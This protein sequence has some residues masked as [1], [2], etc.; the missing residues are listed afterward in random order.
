MILWRRTSKSFWCSFS[1][2]PS[3]CL[4]L[5]CRGMTGKC[6][7]GRWKEIGAKEDG[8]GFWPWVQGAGLV[9][10]RGTL[11]GAMSST[12]G[13]EHG[14]RSYRGRILA[15][16]EVRAIVKTFFAQFLPENRQFVQPQEATDETRNKHGS[17]CEAAFP[18]LYRPVPDSAEYPCNGPKID[19]TILIDEG[20]CRRAELPCGRL[21]GDVAGIGGNLA[22]LRPQR[23]D[24]G[25]DQPL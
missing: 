20:R 4:L 10:F 21:P 6:E 16:E 19:E 12:Y 15:Q 9:D 22:V 23:R 2:R 7:T 14:G 17:R 24:V 13:I 8:S 11:E 3:S 25:D 5:E 1:C 18:R